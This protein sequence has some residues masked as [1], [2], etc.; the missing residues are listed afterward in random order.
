M[1]HVLYHDC[2]GCSQAGTTGAMKLMYRDVVFCR[3]IAY[4]SDLY[5][6][7][8]ISRCSVSSLQASRSFHKFASIDELEL[9]SQFGLVR[10]LHGKMA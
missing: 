10:S 6:I 8:N 1:A 2:G 7:V 4:I 5:S 9:S 3:S